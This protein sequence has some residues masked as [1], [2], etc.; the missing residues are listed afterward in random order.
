[1]NLYSQYISKLALWK[2]KR[3]CFALCYFCVNAKKN[4]QM[5]QVLCPIYYIIVFRHESGNLA[6]SKKNKKPTILFFIYVLS[7]YYRTYDTF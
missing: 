4:I 6:L 7:R 5:L 1:M 3:I 2:L